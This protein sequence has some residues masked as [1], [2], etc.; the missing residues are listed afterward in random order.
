MRY[1]THNCDIY[2]IMIKQLV[3]WFIGRDKAQLFYHVIIYVHGQQGSVVSSVVGLDLP[4][5]V[6]AFAPFPEHDLGAVA[7]TAVPL[8]AV[9]RVEIEVDVVDHPDAPEAVADVAALSP[10]HRLVKVVRVVRHQPD[11]IIYIPSCKSN[12]DFYL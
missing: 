1:C 8:V 12:M 11:L 9:E 7:H 4:A 6:V 3:S 5:L 2:K 10:Q